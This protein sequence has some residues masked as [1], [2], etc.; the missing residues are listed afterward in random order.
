M[1]KAIVTFVGS[2]ALLIALGALN[3]AAQQ[4]V[5][6]G[7]LTCR[8]GP[9]LGRIINA[10][11]RMRCQFV[12]SDGRMENYLGTVTRF[13]LDLDI[14]VGG[15]M[16][17]AVL[18]NTGVTGRGVLAGHYVGASGDIS[19]GIGI[20]AN[21]LI[22]GSRRST[23]LQPVSVADPVGINLAEG[24]AGLALRYSGR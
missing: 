6:A 7:V 21:A 23:V 14:T 2:T 17:W 3:A 20:G 16:R 8:L 18:A 10:R 13:G 11:P 24:V 15:V 4:R 9:S 1:N 5:Q 19:P 12:K 22:G